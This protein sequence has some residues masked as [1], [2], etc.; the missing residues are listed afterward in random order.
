MAILHVKSLNDIQIDVD[1]EKLLL[2]GPA[3][4]LLPGAKFTGEIQNDEAVIYLEDPNKF[5]IKQTPFIAYRDIVNFYDA[6][7][8]GKFLQIGVGYDPLSNTPSLENGMGA[9]IS[10]W[11]ET[12]QDVPTDF[13]W[14]PNLKGGF[15]IKTGINPDTGDHWVLEGYANKKLWWSPNS[16]ISKGRQL[17]YDTGTNYI[18]F[19]NGFRICWGHATASATGEEIQFPVPSTGTM[20][21]STPVVVTC[22]RGGSTSNPALMYSTHINAVTSTSFKAIGMR[23]NGT[24]ITAGAYTFDWVAYGVGGDL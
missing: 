20:F 17:D 13:S 24:T 12:D 19:G 18:R 6:D 8:H 7:V 4:T 14:L 23:L 11:Q 9:S 21:T 2:T 3:Q 5:G 15:E 1:T 16:D 10:L 22:T